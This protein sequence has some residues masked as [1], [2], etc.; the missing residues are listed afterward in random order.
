MSRVSQ[1]SGD[2]DRPLAA[3]PPW[4]V[5]PGDSGTRLERNIRGHMINRGVRQRTRILSALASRAVRAAAR[6]PE[7]CDTTHFSVY[8]VILDGEKRSE[9]SATAHTLFSQRRVIASSPDVSDDSTDD[10]VI[11]D[12][13]SER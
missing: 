8:M 1:H 3:G 11:A 13:V 6:E 4:P 9:K 7:P 10:A 5:W 12:R 2:T